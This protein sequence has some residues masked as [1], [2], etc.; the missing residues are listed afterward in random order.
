VYM[1][2]SELSRVFTPKLRS[3]RPVL[4]SWIVALHRYCKLQGHEDAPWWY[5]ERASLSTLAGAIWAVPNWAA[6]E[7]YA[8]TKKRVM[9]KDKIDEGGL[10]PE[11][12]GRCD[13]LILG[14]S[15]NFAIEAKQAWQSI[16]SRSAGV[17]N[18]HKAMRM[19]WRDAGDLHLDEGE[20]RL[21]V[22]FVVPYVPKKDVGHGHPHELVK[23]WLGSN[24]FK[25]DGRSPAAL[26][27]VFPKGY[28]NFETEDKK[29]YFPGVVLV[30]EHRQR[31]NRNG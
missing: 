12:R 3:L 26:A 5:N 19:A 27:Y 9:P 10:S 4:K 31:G 1:K 29:G 13:L 17:A 24:P 6:L 14:R 15:T 18:V 30:I 20:H 22:T 28:P 21:A 25:I 8:T 7:E 2:D 11:R 16:G 23:Q